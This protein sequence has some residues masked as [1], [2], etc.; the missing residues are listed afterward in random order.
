[1]RSFAQEYPDLRLVQEVLAQVTWYHN[2]TLVEKVKDPDERL[3]YIQQTIEHGWSRAVL[4]H[5]IGR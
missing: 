1:M 5:Q 2:I 3:W 4:V